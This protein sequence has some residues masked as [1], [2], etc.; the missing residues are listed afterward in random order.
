MEN[1]IKVNL[2]KESITL[3]ID[4][5]Q[6]DFSKFVRQVLAQHLDISSSNVMVSSDVDGFDCDE[7]KDI[8]ITV[9]EEFQKDLDVFYD[10]IKKDI[11][12]YY[13]DDLSDEIIKRVKENEDLKTVTE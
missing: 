9:H 4:F 10:N 1:S 5:Q 11:R 2:V 12:T 13:D 3:E 7:F 6:P 8:L